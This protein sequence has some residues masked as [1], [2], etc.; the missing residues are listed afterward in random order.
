[1]FKKI[2]PMIVVAV[3]LFAAGVGVLLMS[4]PTQAAPA[5]VTTS[6]PQGTLTNTGSITA[7]AY[8]AQLA[9]GCGCHFN[10][11]LGG[12][13]GGEDFSDPASGVLQL[14][15]RN[16]TP[17]PTTGI[18]NYTPEQLETVIRTGKR[19]NGEQLFP[20]M[21]YMKFSGIAEDDMD[22]LIAFL[23][24]GQTPISNTIPPRQ[25]LFTVPPFTP[26]V[27]PPATAPVSGLMRGDYIVN[28]L[29][30]CNGCHGESLSGTPGF[31]PNITSDP[32]YGLG[33]LT[34]AQISN[35]LHTGIRPTISDSLRFDGSPIGS[36]MAEVIA[37]AVKFWTDDDVTAVAE[38]LKTV[39]AV[40][41]Q[42]PL[43]LSPPNIS[44]TVGS[45]YVYT[46]VVSDI[47]VFD[48]ITVSA[49]I[50]PDWLNV[51]PTHTEQRTVVGAA[52]LTGTATLSDVGVSPVV[53]VI[54]DNAGAMTTSTFSITV[55]PVGSSLLP[56]ITAREPITPSQR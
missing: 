51:G 19:P 3:M 15:S 18:G 31:A 38:Y 45:S 1:M 41:N 26:T 34:V 35:T 47:D 5:V 48:T 14:Y 6:V 50:K 44:A 20:A 24:E 36:A 9:L 23:L 22:N 37:G 55:E 56:F 7:G 4:T 43:F 27:I 39:P 49:P 11:T 40:G 21:P 46:A 2:A 33:Q 53:L 28:A 17:H 12:L 10:P 54:T 32:D 8:V 52:V 42:P 29:A 30:D 25:L 16:I 13:A